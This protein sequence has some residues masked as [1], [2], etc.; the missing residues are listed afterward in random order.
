MTNRAEA[1]KIIRTI[2]E[3]INEKKENQKA[4]RKR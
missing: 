2:L 4:K 3:T 1:T